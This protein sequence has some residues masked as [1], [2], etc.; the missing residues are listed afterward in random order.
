MLTKITPRRLKIKA[1]RWLAGARQDARGVAAVEF[2]LL[3]PFLLLAFLGTIEIT[4][5]IQLDRK[6][7]MAVSMTSDLVAR[8]E[9]FGETPSEVQATLESI[10]DSIEHVMRPFP[11][12]ELRLAVIPVAASISDATDT[13]VYAPPFIH[14]DKST[15][16]TKCG[17]YTLDNPDLITAGGRVI[18]VEAEYNY[19]PMFWEYMVGPR[20][21]RQYFTA[22]PTWEDKSVHSPRHNCNDFENN[23]CQ[24]PECGRS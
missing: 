24:V 7:D 16:A 4:R 12:E 11:G 19:Q 2:G 1:A 22:D 8:E 15:S 3:V 23:N 21:D 13:Y 20:Y 17:N 10:M 14:N 6:F 5:A 18:V 9:S